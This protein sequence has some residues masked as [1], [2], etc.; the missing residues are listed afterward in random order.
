MKTKLS[1]NINKIAT[2]RNSRGTDAPNLVSFA[3]KFIEHGAEG[4]TIHP[5]ADERHITRKDAGDIAKAIT[6]VETNFEGDIREDFLDMVF[7]HKP[8]Q[9]TL[10]PVTPGEITSN[11]GWDALSQG[12]ILRPVIEEIQKY[13]IRVSLFVDSGNEENLKALCD[14]GADRIEIYTEPYVIG[15]NKGNP[16][17]ELEKIL[18][19]IAIAKSAGMEINAG[20]DLTH[21]NLPTLLRA[22]PE[23]A[24]VSIGHHLISRCIEVGMQQ[25]MREYLE[26]CVVN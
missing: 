20:H 7:K 25:T 26:A 15:F 22:C 23:I 17:P 13:G 8:E 10:V 12:F 14:L 4:I 21:L 11:H 1:V 2:L 24:E 6:S 3:Q 5:R 18:K 9:C 19:T 16:D